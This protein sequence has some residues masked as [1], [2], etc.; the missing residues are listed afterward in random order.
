[1][2]KKLTNLN[3]LV[4]TN[5]ERWDQVIR[6]TGL[7]GL[8]NTGFSFLDRTPLASF[9]DRWHRETSSFHIPGG[10]ITSL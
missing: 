10:E 6:A 8:A 1:N 3:K 7:W 4:P 5:E 9:V 2:G